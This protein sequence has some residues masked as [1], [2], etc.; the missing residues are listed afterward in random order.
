[1]RRRLTDREW[2]YSSHPPSQTHADFSEL[3][4]PAGHRMGWTRRTHIDGKIQYNARCMCKWVDKEN[5]HNV[6]VGSKKLMTIMFNRHIKEVLE[7][8]RS[9][10]L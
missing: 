2:K 10:E 4:L 1:M 8:Q 3:G 6:W 9:L 7:Y 5:G